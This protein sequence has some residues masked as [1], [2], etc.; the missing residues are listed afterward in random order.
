MIIVATT[1]YIDKIDPSLCR[2]LRLT[3]FHFNKLRKQDC[4]EI[5]EKFYQIKLTQEQTDKIIDR[6]I[7]P[8][9]LIHNIEKYLDDSVD[10][11][12]NEIF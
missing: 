4:I 10:N 8:V 9:K 12:I 2:E 3:K 11:L 5:I 7:V 6:H 1:N